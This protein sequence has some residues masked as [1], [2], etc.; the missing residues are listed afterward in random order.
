MKCNTEHPICYVIVTGAPAA[1]TARMKMVNRC[2]HAC[3]AALAMSAP[4]NTTS[5]VVMAS[6][7]QTAA[8]ARPLMRMPGAA[9]CETVVAW[10][11]HML[12]DIPQK[13]QKW[14]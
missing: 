9:N 7:G 8:V 6:M 14:I 10:L 13:S 3:V 2:K 12:V 1:A 4:T 11:V 5:L